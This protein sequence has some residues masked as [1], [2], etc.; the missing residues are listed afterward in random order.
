VSD[1]AEFRV[2]L[3]RELE[4]ELGSART[5]L[6]D[7]LAEHLLLVSTDRAIENVLLNAGLECLHPKGGRYSRSVAHRAAIRSAAEQVFGWLVVSSVRPDWLGTLTPAQHNSPAWYF[8]LPVRTEMGVE[9]IIARRLQRQ[10]KLRT[11]AKGAYAIGTHQVR[12]TENP[13]VWQRKA[14]L[15]DLRI[16]V[17]N[18]VM[19]DERTTPLNAAELE[20]LNER[21]ASLRDLRYDPIHFYLPLRVA[22]DSPEDDFKQCVADLLNDLT[23]LV[24]VRFGF[25]GSQEVFFMP[26][27]RL[28]SATTIFL[29]EIN[30][31]A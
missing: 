5:D 29:N 27:S 24:L 2:A 11:D 19:H 10:A 16:A 17:W 30:K 9:L 4:R 23:N 20:D 14:Q 13:Y 6:P 26:E 8:E 22:K 31:A 12:L 15:Q 3:Q 25:G 28:M 21:I 1:V 7:N 18:A